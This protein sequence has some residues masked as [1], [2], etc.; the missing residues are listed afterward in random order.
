MLVAAVRPP[1]VCTESADHDAPVLR[2]VLWAVTLKA[3][4]LGAL[5]LFFVKPLEPTRVDARSTAAA[6]IGAAGE[7]TSGARSQDLR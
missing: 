5:Y 4:L 2:D 1:D 7:R 6:I 3:L